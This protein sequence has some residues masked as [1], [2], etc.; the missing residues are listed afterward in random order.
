MAEARQSQASRPEADAGFSS[1]GDSWSLINR[2]YQLPS[3]SGSKR[4]IWAYLMAMMTPCPNFESRSLVKARLQPSGR[5]GR[6]QI[7]ISFQFHPGLVQARVEALVPPIRPIQRWIGC[8]EDSLQDSS[9][10]AGE[11]LPDVNHLWQWLPYICE[12]TSRR[13]ALSCQSSG[14]YLGAFMRPWCV[15]KVYRMLPR[16]GGRG[17]WRQPVFQPGLL[18]AWQNGAG[19]DAIMMPA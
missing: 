10:I 15:S 7:S 6:Q 12:G 4:P 9:R 1:N 8:W 16:P 11:K 18:P 13:P 19:H 14:R 5:C 2:P 3:R 17:C